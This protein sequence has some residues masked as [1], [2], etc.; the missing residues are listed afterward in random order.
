MIHLRNN[1]NPLIAPEHRYY[2][3]LI[4]AC[5]KIK[6][7]QSDE[8]T[9]WWL[10]R[11][12]EEYIETRNEIIRP[13]VHTYNTVMENFAQL[14]HAVKAGH[15]MLEVLYHKGSRDTWLR[16]NNEFFSFFIK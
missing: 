1:V 10:H 8:Q 16:P 7:P 11:M 6:Q 13:K 2:N 4:S 5:V 9:D 12:W 14:G 3:H 15:L